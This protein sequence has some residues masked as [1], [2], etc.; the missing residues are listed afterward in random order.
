M[1][2]TENSFLGC[3]WSFPPTFDVGNHQ[4]KITH[5]IQNI[6]DS[7]D[8]IL[9]SNFGERNLNEFFG[10]DLRRFFFKEMDGN[11]QGE[12]KQAVKAAL[13]DY[14]PRIIVDRVE[15]VFQDR[16]NGMVEIHITY[17]IADTNTRHNHVFPFYIK[18]G[19]NLQN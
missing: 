5:G 1:D 13:L 9:L 7:I 15:V 17:T 14:E 6:N 18:E 12:I 8:I 19:T 11:L 16:S 10:G 2:E 4:L 3:G